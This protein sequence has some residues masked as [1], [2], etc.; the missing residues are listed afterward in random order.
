MDEIRFPKYK[1]KKYWTSGDEGG[2]EFAM[3]YPVNNSMPQP[4]YDIDIEAW[5]K[6]C[7]GDWPRKNMGNSSYPTVPRVVDDWFEKWFSQFNGRKR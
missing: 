7:M 3:F 6:R 1:D 5:F 2:Q 4:L